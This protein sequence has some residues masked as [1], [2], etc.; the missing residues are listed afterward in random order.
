MSR[1]PRIT[2]KCVGNDKLW[3]LVLAHEICNF[4]KLDYL[5]TPLV[6][7]KLVKRNENIM[8]STNRKRAEIHRELGATPSK[9]A[10]SIK[11]EYER[12]TTVLGKRWWG[13]SKD[14][15]PE[16]DPFYQSLITKLNSK[17]T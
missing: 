15:N 13:G 2:T 9:R 12:V 1:R 3:N 6:I 16:T 8:G 5:V 11:L 14:F 10:S 17:I 7:E 4:Q